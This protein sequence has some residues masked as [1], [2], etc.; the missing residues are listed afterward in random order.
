MRVGVPVLGPYKSLGVNSAFARNEHHARS[1]SEILKK[2][3]ENTGGATQLGGRALTGRGADLPEPRIVDS[4]LFTMR[5][6]P[7]ALGSYNYL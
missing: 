1:P 7:P 3:Q 5:L 4:L 2:K 6:G